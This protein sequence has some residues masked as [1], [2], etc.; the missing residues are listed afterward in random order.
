[1]QKTLAVR[2]SEIMIILQI[3]LWSISVMMRKELWIMEKASQRC[4]KTPTQHIESLYHT[5]SNRK[6]KLSV[7]WFKRLLLRSSRECCKT[8]HGIRAALDTAHSTQ[9]FRMPSSSHN[10]SATLQPF[11]F[12]PLSH[13]P[14]NIYSTFYFLFHFAPFFIL[15]W[16]FMFLAAS[17]NLLVYERDVRL[18]W[19][20]HYLFLSFWANVLTSLLS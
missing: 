12:P 17:K 19:V 16:F 1:M 7:G 15:F 2:Y 3:Y 10:F 11:D 13:Q 5:C 4:F 14:W 18:L 8:S 6:K 9:S 20:Q